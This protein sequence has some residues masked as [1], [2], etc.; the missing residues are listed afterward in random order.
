VN[1]GALVSRMNFALQLTS[2]RL[3]KTDV[4]L[5]PAASDAANPQAA[6]DRLIRGALASDVAETTRATIARATTPE[7]AAA[8]TLGSPEFQRR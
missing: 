4:A 3:P 8:L 2:G 7:Q 5:Q 6:G 1:T